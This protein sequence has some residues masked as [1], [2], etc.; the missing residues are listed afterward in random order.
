VVSQTHPTI[1]Q[2]CYGEIFSIL[3]SLVTPRNLTLK[4]RL[5][6]APNPVQTDSSVSH[7]DSSALP[8]QV[9]EPNIASDLLHVVTAP[10]DLTFSLLKDLGWTGPLMIFVEQGTTTAAALDSVTHV[11][12]LFP[13]LNPNNLNTNGDT[14]TRL[15]FFTSYLGPNPGDDLSAILARANGIPLVVEAA[16]QE[17]DIGGSYIVVR[18][19]GLPQGSYALSVNYRGVN[20]TNAPTITIVGQ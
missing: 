12:G 1:I 6:F 20:S 19:G 7:W 5:M 14:R 10:H 3:A 17:T 2:A 15:I 18:L 16:G 13:N 9:M 4:S 8:N 11:R